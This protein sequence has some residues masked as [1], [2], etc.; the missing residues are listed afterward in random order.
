MTSLA[1]FV[2]TTRSAR[3]L[4]RVRTAEP[5]NPKRASLRKLRAA[6]TRKVADFLAGRVDD[7]AASI[8]AQLTARELRKGVLPDAELAAIE[9]IVAGVDFAGWS[10]LVGDIEGILA[11]I[12]RDGTVHALVQVG[13]G[14]QASKEVANVVSPYAV[15]YGRQRA[16]EMVGMRVDALGALVPNPRA[17]W[18]VTEGTREYIRA[19]VREAIEEGLSNDSIAARLRESY[20]FSTARAT[21]I[22]RTETLRA[23]NEGALQGYKASGVVNAKE[24]LTAEDD[25]V[26][27]DCM[28]NQGAGAI[29]LDAAFPSGEHAPPDHPNCRCTILP[30]VDWTKADN[31]PSSLTE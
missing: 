8:G 26:T 21:L 5:L 22:A 13:I 15:E 12:I 7:M 23:S 11:D 14:T 29:P 27:P 18:R 6:L 31:I 19:T 30:V 4:R 16:A 3:V 20:G 24:W 17:H 1:A 10:A 2:T 25:K 28:A 9:A